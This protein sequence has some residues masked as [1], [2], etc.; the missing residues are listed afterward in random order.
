MII[1]VQCI[2]PFFLSV[3]GNSNSIV[4]KELIIT[5]LL[6][7][8]FIA[9][10]LVTQIQHSYPFPLINHFQI[11]VDLAF[12]STYLIILKPRAR[13]FF[14]YFDFSHSF[15][16][17]F[18]VLIVAGTWLLSLPYSRT[19]FIP[20]ID[21]FLT[22]TAAVTVT[23]T[24]SIN[25][26][27]DLTFFGR[28]VL[29]TLVQL[30]GLGIIT[31]SAFYALSTQQ[32]TN[33]GH[34]ISTLMVF[35]QNETAKLKKLLTTIISST[36][37]I[38]SFG[39]LLIHSQTKMFISNYPHP[40]FFSIFYAINAFCNAGFSLIIPHVD[41]LKT[42]VPFLYTLSTL[43]FLGGLGFF[44]FLEILQKLKSWLLQ[45]FN[46]KSF[47]FS[48]AAKIVIISSIILF[49]IGAFGFYFLERNNALIGF[50]GLQKVHQSIFQSIIART[51]GFQSLDITTYKDSTL[52]LLESLM[53][54]GTSPGS[55][56][57]GMKVTTLFILIWGVISAIRHR[58]A[59]FSISK[60]QIQPGIF[61]KA[62]CILFLRISV[63]ILA[64]FVVSIVDSQFLFKYLL[65]EITSLFS[66]AG[67]STGIVSEF[68]VYAKI[69]SMILMFVGRIGVFYFIIN[70]FNIK[71]RKTS[72]QYTQ[73]TLPLE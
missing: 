50:H 21:L 19:H 13:T 25:I 18:I 23:G 8:L 41:I 5:I 36:I 14:K 38:E 53:F 7:G 16:L 48:I 34:R 31:F 72:I 58:T 47:S 10:R 51:A 69:I 62:A 4:Y 32:R 9:Q 28:M 1:I 39:A 17:G 67:L 11:T 57:G 65:F 60:Y 30:G 64:L 20:V 40:W 61:F 54:I 24:T 22:S 55:T 12:Y 35:N 43:I 6:F 46:R 26:N 15:T 71:E 70:L 27:T 2:R 33:Y 3:T 37:I 66:G 42:S 73:L 29:L 56:G 63:L 45:G 44:V 49:L 52:L 59:K 68:S